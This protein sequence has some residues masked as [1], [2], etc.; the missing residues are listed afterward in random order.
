MEVRDPPEAKE[1]E[2]PRNFSWIVPDELAA[3]A[4]PDTRDHLKTL[5]Y[6]GVCHLVSLS[7]ECI[8]DGIERYEPLNW[9]L[10][11]VEEYHAPTMRQVIK[12]I[13]FCVNCRQKGEVR[14]IPW[15]EFLI[16]LSIL[17]CLSQI[18]FPN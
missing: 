18:S 2:G 5:S 13:E 9:I 16:V 3:M 6:R 1:K 7:E 4:C 14:C 12:F 11:P 15:K 8:P 17:K 10:I